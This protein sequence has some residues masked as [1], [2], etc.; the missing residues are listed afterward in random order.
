[1]EDANMVAVEQVKG[2]LGRLGRE[3]TLPLFVLGTRA[4]IPRHKVQQGLEGTLCARSS[5]V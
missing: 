5:S 2:L 3:E 4:T 1:M